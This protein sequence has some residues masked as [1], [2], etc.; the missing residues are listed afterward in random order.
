VHHSG[1]NLFTFQGIYHN[2][3]DLLRLAEEVNTTKSPRK[4]MRDKETL[5]VIM[6]VA[7]TRQSKKKRAK[8]KADFAAF[9]SAAGSWSD[10]DA[11]KLI[12]DIY[13]WRQEGSRLPERS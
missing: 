12:A 4:L 5:A 11:E 2:H 10:V 3:P 6:P 7:T 13:R 9:K 1:Q 8:T